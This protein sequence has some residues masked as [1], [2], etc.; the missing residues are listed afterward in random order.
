MKDER[1]SGSC[2]N[3]FSCF[4]SFCQSLAGSSVNLI[5]TCPSHGLK[6]QPNVDLL[7]WPQAFRGGYQNALSFQCDTAGQMA[8]LTTSIVMLNTLPQGNYL[9]PFKAG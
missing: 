5:S 6:D 7:H 2:F 4:F 9:L 1:N 8:M 3:S